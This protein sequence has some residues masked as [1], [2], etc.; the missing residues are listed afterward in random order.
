MS[1]TKKVCPKH[2]K[3]K[4]SKN[5]KCHVRRPYIK[6]FRKQAIIRIEKYYE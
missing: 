6:K 3:T 4:K 5:S 2:P 1:K